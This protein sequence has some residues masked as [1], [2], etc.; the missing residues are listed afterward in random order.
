MKVNFAS[1]T[2]RPT[3]PPPTH[4]TN[5]KASTPQSN[6]SNVID[7]RAGSWWP[8]ANHTAPSVAAATLLSNSSAATSAPRRRTDA[9]C[10][11]LVALL[12]E[13]IRITS[14]IS[15]P[16]DTRAPACRNQSSPPPHYS[17]RVE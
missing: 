11:R 6:P 14:E 3:F 15:F 13:A 8:A 7:Q 9:D 17:D 1:I 2:K 4:P 5:M 12:D 16:R 10:Q